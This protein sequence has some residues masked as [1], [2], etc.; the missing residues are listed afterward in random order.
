MF[1]R[2]T[3]LGRKKS[4]RLLETRLAALTHSI[5]QFNHHDWSCWLERARCG[6]C[7]YAATAC[8]DSSIHAIGSLFLDTPGYRKLK[9]TGFA[10][11]STFRPQRLRVPGQGQLTLASSGVTWHKTSLAVGPA[12]I[13]FKS[14]MPEPAPSPVPETT[15]PSEFVEATDLSDF[16]LSTIPERIGY[17]KELGLDYGWGSSSVAQYFIEHFH[18]W[19]GMPWW[20][21]IVATGLLFRGVLLPFALMASDQAAR[22]HNAKP[23][24]TPLREEM[25]RHLQQGN[26]IAGQQKRAELSEI[27]RAHGI[28]V[29]KTLVPLLQ[30]PLGFGIFRA[31]RGMTSLPLPAFMDESFFW[32][33][34]LTVADPVYILPMITS[35]AMYLTFKV[36][37]FLYPSSAPIANYDH[38]KVASPA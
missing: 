15:T 26:Q 7:H 20:A 13:R 16:D 1:T 18:V 23:L 9:L 34:D 36:C 5:T 24:T 2:D 30:I 14:S 22:S 25:M 29:W 35:F 21:G 4:P 17:L 10:Q 28:K 6:C 3:P 11:I 38:R 32:I 12:A 33:K 37:C 31:T 19:G 27:H 8:C